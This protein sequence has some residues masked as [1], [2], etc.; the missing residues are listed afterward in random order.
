MQTF[1]KDF[2][3]SKVDCVPLFAVTFFS[4]SVN[5]KHVSFVLNANLC[6][7]LKLAIASY[8]AVY[9]FPGLSVFSVHSVEKEGILLQ[10]ENYIN[11]P[12]KY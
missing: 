3:L 12:Y 4:E 9:F 1:K 5:Y 8:I 11:T 6:I 2:L 7:I 10:I